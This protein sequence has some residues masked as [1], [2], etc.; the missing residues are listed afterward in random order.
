MEE[1]VI[2][3]KKP[4]A[5]KTLGKLVIMECKTIAQCLGNHIRM[6]NQV[7]SYQIRTLRTSN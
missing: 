3:V 1:L 6:K 5:F 4:V 7:R 2:E